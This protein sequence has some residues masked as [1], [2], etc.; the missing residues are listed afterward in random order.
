MTEVGADSGELTLYLGKANL[1]NGRYPEAIEAL[2]RAVQADPRLPFVHYELGVAYRNLRQLEKSKEEFLADA[3]IEPD[4]SYTFDQLGAVCAALE[5]YD[6]ALG[7]FERALQLNP[8]LA[9]SHFGLAKIYRQRERYPEALHALDQANRLDPES[10]SVH[11]LRGQVLRVL[12]RTEEA[13][14]EFA[15]VRELVNTTG[16]GVE[17]QIRGEATVDPQLA[18]TRH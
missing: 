12:H 2:Q 14:Q 1:A 4:V 15:R 9:A 8:S 16:D 5:E 10:S 7:Y 11:Y 6:E 17:R 13:R 3:A 18:G